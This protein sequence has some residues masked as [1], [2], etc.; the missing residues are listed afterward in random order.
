[1]SNNELFN[2]LKQFDT[3]TIC[4]AIE[5][6]GIRPRTCGFGPA[7]NGAA[8]RRLSHPHGRLCS[9]CQDRSHVPRDAG[10]ERTEVSAV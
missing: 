7:G 8:K 6:F 1:M 10:A 5:L 4:N 2:S 3:P 9:N